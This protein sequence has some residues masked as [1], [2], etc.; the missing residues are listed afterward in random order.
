MTGAS[1]RSASRVRLKDVVRGAEQQQRK[2][3]DSAWGEI[4]VWGDPS[5]AE[6]SSSRCM[7]PQ[8]FRQIANLGQSMRSQALQ[9]L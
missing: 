2:K 7:Q 8:I 3:Q 5:R 6:A 1:R 9:S 4:G